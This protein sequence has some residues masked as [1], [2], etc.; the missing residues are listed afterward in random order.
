MAEGLAFSQAASVIGLRGHAPP[1]IIMSIHSFTEPTT[2]KASLLAIALCGAACA[3]S[4]CASAVDS[5]AVQGTAQDGESSASL[6]F[7]GVHPKGPV[8]LTRA[9]DIAVAEQRTY[10]VLAD[11]TARVWGKDVS[12]RPVRLGTYQNLRRVGASATEICLLDANG[13]LICTKT[14]DL[15]GFRTMPLAGPVADF[16]V[17]LEHS[18]AVLRDGRAYCWGS[19]AV[20]QLGDGTRNDQ[21]NPIAAAPGNLFAEIDG[22]RA[23]SCGRRFD[24]QVMCWGLWHVK[25]GDGIS[26]VFNNPTVLVADAIRSVEV[27]GDSILAMR[28]DGVALGLGAGASLNLHGVQGSAV[29]VT[30]P[31]RV[32]EFESYTNV[33]LRSHGG[34]GVRANGVVNCWGSNWF[35]EIGSG[36]IVLG[37]VPMTRVLDLDGAS[38]VVVASATKT[39]SCAILKDGN[40]KCWGDNAR[41]QLGDGTYETRFRAVPVSL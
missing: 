29:F 25:S 16:H 27:G 5:E 24:G 36:A 28:A 32:P 17:A 9:V 21:R 38:K 2:L 41:G 15:S 18:C 22:S 12:T 4:G 33:S 11:G 7:T 23:F 39:H 13:A 35:G 30:S 34:C 8:L 31:T 14:L 6:G 10:A 19:N 40:V 20:G 3:A 37:D 26:Q 1:E